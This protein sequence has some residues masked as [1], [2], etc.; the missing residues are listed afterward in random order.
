[1]CVWYTVCPIS[2][3]WTQKIKTQLTKTFA[4]TFC[5]YKNEYQKFLQYHFAKS[6]IIGKLWS[7]GIL[8]IPQPE[9]KSVFEMNKYQEIV[10]IK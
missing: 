3:F 1:M 2:I 4:K 5:T 10:L 8:K 9:Y 6:E 7:P